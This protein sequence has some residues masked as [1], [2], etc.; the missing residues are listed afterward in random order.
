[1]IGGGGIERQIHRNNSTKSLWERTHNYSTNI[2]TT[3]RHGY[4]STSLDLEAIPIRYS[5]YDNSINVLG[6]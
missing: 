3:V 1:M 5:L 2:R 4:V 6:I